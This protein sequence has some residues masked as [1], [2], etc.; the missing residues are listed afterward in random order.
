MAL[1]RSEMEP[2]EA[3]ETQRESSG[4]APIA[5]VGDVEGDGDSLRKEGCSL[6]SGIVAMIA[7]GLVFPVDY[8]VFDPLVACAS[9]KTRVMLL[10]E[11]FL[12]ECRGLCPAAASAA[13]DNVLDDT[14]AVEGRDTGLMVSRDLGVP[15]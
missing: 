7:N 15:D 2:V 4:H 8:A 5:G 6:S 11:Y 1:D 14:V 13:F 12:K 9:F 10:T 3:V